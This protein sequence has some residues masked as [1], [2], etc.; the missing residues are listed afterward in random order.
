MLFAFIYTRQVLLAPVIFVL[1]AMA[2]MALFLFRHSDAA[3]RWTA[4]MGISAL[5]PLYISLPLSMLLHLDRF[6]PDGNLW[7]FFLL[8]VIFA[9]DTGAYYSGKLFGRHKL[10]E[11]VSPHKTWEGAVGGLFLSV[12]AGAWFLAFIRLRPLSPEI[13]IVIVCLAVLGQIGDL[14]ESM[15]KRNQGVKDS[16]GIL[17]GHGGILDRIDALLFAIPALYL[18]LSLTMV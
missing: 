11:A 4:Q 5:G 17:P 8:T 16:G 18:Y 7:I 12:I 10:Y 1:W 14:V 15:I 2:P 3:D 6:I 9:N 13:F